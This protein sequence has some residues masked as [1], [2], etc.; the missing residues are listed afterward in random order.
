SPHLFPILMYKLQTI[1]LNPGRAPLI[2]VGAGFLCLRA[3]DR[4]ATTDIGHDRVGATRWV[5]QRHLVLFARMPAILVARAARQKATKDTMLR[6]ENGQMMVGDDL[7]LLR[8]DC[9]R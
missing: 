3:K 9:L 5:T 4:V 8:A 2:Q 7:H 1:M 6:V